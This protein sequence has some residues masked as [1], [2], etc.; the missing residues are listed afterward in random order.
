MTAPLAWANMKK[1]ETRMF[2]AYGTA[3]YAY[4]TT[5]RLAATHFFNAHPTKRKC[6]VIE[7][8]DDGASFVIKFGAPWP[9]SWKNVTNKTAAT[10]PD[11]LTGE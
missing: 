7:G 8:W 5:P 9:K 1:P 3:G 10:L 2:K 4:G 11:T 6:D